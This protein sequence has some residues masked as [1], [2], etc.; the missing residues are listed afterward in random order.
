MKKI[1][2][3]RKVALKFI[4]VLIL[5]IFSGLPSNAKFIGNQE[6]CTTIPEEDV[7]G[8]CFQTCKHTFYFL[9]IPVSTGYSYEFVFC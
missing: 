6:T 4:V 9:W 3:I 2:I 1:S 8:L 5:L 7:P